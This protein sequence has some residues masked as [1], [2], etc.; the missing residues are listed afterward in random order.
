MRALGRRGASIVT[1]LCVAL[2]AGCVDAEEADTR[3]ASA[4][5]EYIEAVLAGDQSQVDEL[6][7]RPVDLGDESTALGGWVGIDK[8]SVTGSAADDVFVSASGDVLWTGTSDDGSR[9]WSV[10]VVVKVEALSAPN[11]G[12]AAGLPN[13]RT[14]SAF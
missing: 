6:A 2:A 14:P 8:T 1:A 3:V 11:S 7:D 4:A 10:D 5:C 13:S 12:S 9:E